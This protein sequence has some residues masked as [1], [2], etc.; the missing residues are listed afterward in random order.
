MSYQK[1]VALLSCCLLFSMSF[2][3]LALTSVTQ[4]TFGT[5]SAE[6]LK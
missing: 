2:V 1:S 6:I 5:H 4:S 3:N